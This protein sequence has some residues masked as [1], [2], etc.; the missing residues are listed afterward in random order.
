MARPN[1]SLPCAVSIRL[2]NWITTTTAVFCQQ[3][4]ESSLSSRYAV[5]GRPVRS[6]PFRHEVPTHPMPGLKSPGFEAAPVLSPQGGDTSRLCVGHSGLLGFYGRA[7]STQSSL[8]Q[9]VGKNPSL[10]QR[11]GITSALDRQSPCSYSKATD[12]HRWLE[13]VNRYRRA[14]ESARMLLRIAP[15]KERLSFFVRLLI[16][17]LIRSSPNERVARIGSCS[18]RLQPTG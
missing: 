12:V 4:C 7:S 15:A 11:V 3:Y 6:M 13:L 14:R 10:T 2:L 18:R 9:R 8:T 17:T 16:S 5:R 1:S